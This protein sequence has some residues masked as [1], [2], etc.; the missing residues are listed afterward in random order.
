MLF[1]DS[2]FDGFAND[3]KIFWIACTSTLT[4]FDSSFVS[5]ISLWKMHFFFIRNI[6]EFLLFFSWWIIA[7]HLFKMW[8]KGKATATTANRCCFFTVNDENQREKRSWQPIKTCTWICFVL[9][10]IFL[11]EYENVAVRYHNDD[12]STLSAICFCGYFL[13]CSVARRDV[14]CSVFR[15]SMLVTYAS[16][17]DHTPKENKQKKRKILEY[18]NSYCHCLCLR[19]WWQCQSRSKLRKF[20]MQNKIVCALFQWD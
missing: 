14:H 10:I 20:L 19:F 13:L 8:K 16:T 12:T 1:F 11:W 5:Y 9:K 6:S 17:T 7:F 18:S 3:V 2:F 4:R 15:Q